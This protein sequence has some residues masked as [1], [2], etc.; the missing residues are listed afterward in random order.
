M[1]RPFFMN[2]NNEDQLKKEIAEQYELSKNYL[3]PI[4]KRF[5][6][7][8]EMYR[9]YIN[10]SN[11]DNKA[12]VFDPRTFRV[13][14]TVAPR[15]VANDPIGSYY[16]VEKGDMAV[17]N[18]LNSVLKYDWEK[19]GMFVKLLDFV[20]SVLIFGTGFGRIYWDYRECEKTRMVPK[21]INGK[22]VWDSK[23]QEKY[24]SVEYDGPNFEPLNIY[25]CFPDPN[26]KSVDTMR[27]FIYRRFRTL[28]ELKK[29]NDARGGEFYKNLD[30]LENRLSAKKEEPRGT[31][32]PVDSEYR[33]HRRVMLSTQEYIGEDDSNPDIAILR[34]YEGERL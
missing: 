15:M 10:P 29:E 32:K 20:K 5:N 26:S 16:P 1:W 31:G 2:N 34:R 22:T 12:K 6:S 8:E 21:K 13:I 25:D 11:T 27:W 18:V 14:E 9:S 28:S 30:E 4:H 7:L 24:T 17:A 33:E 3:D 19:A 23:N